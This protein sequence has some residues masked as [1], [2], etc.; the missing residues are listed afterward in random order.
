MAPKCNGPNGFVPVRPLD[1]QVL[2][3]LAEGELHGYG[4]V[5]AAQEQFPDQPSLKI[6]SLYRI[7]SRMLDHQWIREV[8]RPKSQPR[9]N[10]VRRYYTVTALGRAVIRAEAGRMRALL[11]SPAALRLLEAD[12]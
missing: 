8:P 5:R 3:I 2:T 11:A 4:I 1:F 10:R 7:V 12:R 9:D 6:G